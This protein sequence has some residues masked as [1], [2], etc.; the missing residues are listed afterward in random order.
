MISRL[1]PA[2]FLG[3]AALFLPPLGSIAL[4]SYIESVGRWLRGHDAQG[5]AFYSVGFA[6]LAGLAL[7]PTYASAVLG[8]WAF[9]FVVG[10]PAALAGFA[11][12]AM[13]G[14]W[15]GRAG[16]GDRVETIIA[17]KP[18]WKAV[19]DALIGGGFLKT[20]GII[21]LVRLPPNSPFALTNLVLSS[22]KAHRL[23]YILGTMA[24]M[25]PRTAVAVYIAAELRDLSA[26]E[27]A[28]AERPLW[29]WIAG[30]TT[31]LGA[32]VVLGIIANKAL[33]K[34]TR[35]NGAPEPAGGVPA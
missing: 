7:L 20:L 15:T 16:S 26:A 3:A 29:V 4:F 34:A 32:L 18:K 17:E 25:A 24:G 14:Y 21:T 10:F 31:A 35:K 28:K 30:I 6:I 9:G 23:A 1:G 19:R 12:G 8:G 5:V 22:V 13:I 33:A 11:G 27:A 2:A